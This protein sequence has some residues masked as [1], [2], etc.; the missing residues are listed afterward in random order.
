[1]AFL[2]SEYGYASTGESFSIS[3]PNEMWYME[4]IGKGKK[5]TGAVWVARRVPDGYVTG[6]ANQARITTFPQNDPENCVFSPDVI[7]FARD[8]GLYEGSDSDFSFSDT[9]DPVDF[10]GARFCEARVW[11]FFSTV[12]GKEWSDEYL[13]Y[14]QGLDLTNR[15]PLWVKPSVQLSPQDVM[16][17]M[18][19]HYE[20]T[21]LDNTGKLFPDIGAAQYSYPNRNSPITWSP[22]SNP[23]TQYFNERTIAQPPTGWSIVCQSRPGVPRQMAALM[24]FGI[25][26]S[27]TS[28]HFPV[29]GSVTRIP[30]GWAGQGPQ[31]GVTPP[32][33]EFSLDSAFY[34][35]NLVANYAYSRW[36]LI[37]ADVHQEIVDRE[38]RYF[39]MVSDADAKA[40]EI[41]QSGSESEGVEF[42]TAFS[43]DI[44]AKLLRDWFKFFGKLFVKFR[45]GY[46][47]T[48]SPINP[49]C[50]C[51]TSSTG[52]QDQWYDHIAEDTG[53]RYK[54][55][56][57][58]AD[59]TTFRKKD[60]RSFN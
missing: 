23:E 57:E 44:G 34:V 48:A 6:H 40:I 3:D 25:D 20:G 4:L 41:F 46:V 8:I 1:M 7:S 33:M 51:S 43:Y 12:M 27:S 16:E 55:P 42:L 53:D 19:N 30:E 11:S 49:V 35:F 32:L 21:E 60:L 5:A 56:T 2:V 52:Y 17:N 47:T 59:R 37:Y 45:D 14:A 31:D 26:D 36:D 24:W 50:G 15:M 28:V 13:S 22:P 10:D 18:R 39:N 54:V 58:Q 38:A 9:Y 29:Y